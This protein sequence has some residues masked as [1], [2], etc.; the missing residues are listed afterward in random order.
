[1]STHAKLSPSAG[2]RWLACAVA[3]SREEAFEDKGSDAAAWGTAAHAMAEWCLIK[4]I[5]AKDAPAHVDWD[6]WDGVEMRDCVQHYLDFVRSK[7]TPSSTLFVEQRLSIMPEFGIFGTA[8][9]IIV[10]GNTLRVLDLKG[11]TGVLV[12]ADDNPQLAMYGWGAYST[13]DWLA[14]EEITHVEVSICQP[15]RNNTV[16]KTFTAAE[17]KEWMVVNEPKARKAHR[18]VATDVAVPGAHCIWC[19]ARHTCKERAEYNLATAAMDFEMMADPECAPPNPTQISEEQLVSIFL[20]LPM[21]EKWGKDVEAEVARRAH[22]HEVVGLKW[23]AG[24]NMRFITDASAAAGVLEVA[25]VNPY[26]ERKMLGFGDLEKAAKAVGQKLNDLIGQFIDKRMSPPVLVSAEDK[27]PAYVAAAED[28][29]EELE[30]N[31]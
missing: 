12:D 13:L 10:D 11:G 24:K 22:E 25:G 30:G 6:Q 23:V 5:D 4:L 28:F 9:A 3:P 31:A 27:R 15:R 26:A 7:L 29:K 16:S 8:D 17:L 1:M 19:K 21:L 20:R 14:S 2:E 18:A